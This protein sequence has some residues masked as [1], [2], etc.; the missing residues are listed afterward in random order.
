MKLTEIHEGKY[1]VT[2]KNWLIHLDENKGH[3]FGI[4]IEIVDMFEMT[5]EKEFKQYPFSV[6]MS[7]VADK[8]HKSFYE[9]EGRPT[10]LGL[11]E[12]CVGYM[13]GVPVEHVLWGVKTAGTDYEK[14]IAMFSPKEACVIEETQQFG[15]WAAQNGKDKPMQY[16]RFKTHDAAY[17]YTEQ[18]MKLTGCLGMMIGFILDRPIN[19]MGETG[20]RTITKMINGK[21]SNR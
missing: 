6:S 18:M 2:D 17:K 15:T 16:M 11:I 12:D 5:G 10:K 13:G 9:G 14:I 7:L 4:Y 21:N 3:Q 8:P 19:M 20:W 1:Y